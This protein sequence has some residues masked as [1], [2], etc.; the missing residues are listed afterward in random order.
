MYRTN[1]IFPFLFSF[2]CWSPGLIP[3]TENIWKSATPY[4]YSKSHERSRLR[5]SSDDSVQTQRSVESGEEI[6]L[7]RKLGEIARPPYRQ[8]IP[9]PE[10]LHDQKKDGFKR[11]LKEVASPPHHRVTA[12]GRIVPTGTQSPP[13]MMQFDSLEDSVQ[14]RQARHKS[15]AKNINRPEAP[16]SNALT[17]YSKLNSR[18]EAQGKNP[19]NGQPYLFKPKAGL[20]PN[21][22]TGKTANTASLNN[23]QPL[24]YPISAAAVPFGPLPTPFASNHYLGHW[25]GTS[26]YNQLLPV[27]PYSYVEHAIPIYG[28]PYAPPQDMLPAMTGNPSLVRSSVDTSDHQL[29]SLIALPEESLAKNRDEYVAKLSD[30]DKHIALNLH[31]FTPNQVARNAARR[32]ELVKTI[33]LFRVAMETSSK[34]ATSLSVPTTEPNL[35]PGKSQPVFQPYTMSLDEGQQN[36]G[37]H[38]TGYANQTTS[39]PAPAGS[40]GNS[41]TS[42][43]TSLSAV[44]PPFIPGCFNVGL[45][46]LNFEDTSLETR[47]QGTTSESTAVCNGNTQLNASSPSHASSAFGKTMYSNDKIST[48][49]DAATDS[50][51]RSPFA[52]PEVDLR[53]IAY[54]DRLGLN[55]PHREKK[56]C[57]T[58]EEFQEVIRRAREQATAYSCTP[59]AS[60]DPAHDAEEDI[61]CAMQNEEAIVLP[62]PIPDHIANPR[63]WNWLDSAYNA[64]AHPE[65]AS[66]LPAEKALSPMKSV[67]SSSRWSNSLHPILEEN[68]SDEGAHG[69]GVGVAKATSHRPENSSQCASYVHRTGVSSSEIDESAFAK[70]QV[71]MAPIAESKTIYEGYNGENTWGMT[72]GQNWKAIRQVDHKNT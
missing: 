60:K 48:S 15:S 58:V 27:P 29:A 40:V 7:G 39:T 38:A 70:T 45:S 24:G 49:D 17:V 41:S 44:A 63:P 12:G 9:A 28:Q 68:S 54:V 37:L 22:N 57:S 72:K 30:L 21:Q 20:F 16:Q 34:N 6:V 31:K 32:E 46:R 66:F 67:D 64:R 26:M 62:Q 5:A 4:V 3:L 25:N 53:D 47:R 35:F 71:S 23:Q 10:E 59:G 1:S 13:I 55:P 65:F 14:H 61:R 50:R 42:Q 43:P 52:V 11:F 33:D 56:F 2:A 36:V 19:S 51:V 18:V 69:H 8:P